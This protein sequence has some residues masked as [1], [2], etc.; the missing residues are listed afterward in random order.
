MHAL[1]YVLCPKHG[2][3]DSK[4]ARSH[5][6]NWLSDNGFTENSG[7]FQRYYADWF[8]VGGRW[9]GELTS[10]QLDQEKIKA[11]NNEF[12]QK[13]GFWIS[14]DITEEIRREQYRKITQK[15]FPDYKGMPWA[16]RDSYQEEG[17][18]DDAQIVNRPLFDRIIKDHLIDE[19]SQE[20]LWNGGAVIAT[21]IQD[22]KDSITPDRFIGKYWIV[23]V[24]FHF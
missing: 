7:L 19:I 9:S 13:Y 1:L 10:N 5:V 20:K 24:D 8:V 3:A 23:V 15:Y 22:N 17:Y 11:L 2:L 21:D 6:F 14:K 12:E 4:S 18:E 16:F